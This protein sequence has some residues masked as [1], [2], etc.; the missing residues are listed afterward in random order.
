[1]QSASRTRITS[2]TA[3]SLAGANDVLADLFEDLE[4][5][6]PTTVSDAPATRQVGFDMR[7]AG[8]EHSLTVVVDADRGRVTADATAIRQAFVDEYAR[9][10]GQSIE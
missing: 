4:A 2:L 5:R 10:F 8:Q 7:Y 6:T 1:M 9:T 3:E